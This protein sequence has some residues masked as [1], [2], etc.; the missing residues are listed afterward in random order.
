MLEGEREPHDYILLLSDPLTARLV[1][2]VDDLCDPGTARHSI[3]VNTSTP[4]QCKAVP[5]LFTSLRTVLSYWKLNSRYYF[6]SSYLF[7]ST[8]VICVLSVTSP[9]HCVVSPLRVVIVCCEVARCRR[10]TDSPLP[11]PLCSSL[12]LSVCRLSPGLLA[13]ALVPSCRA[14]PASSSLYGSTP[15]RYRYLSPLICAFC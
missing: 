8:V 6:T 11:P 2:S 15:P 12:C 3:P 7:H 13:A 1:L 14:C 4:R 5:A 10:R 9:A